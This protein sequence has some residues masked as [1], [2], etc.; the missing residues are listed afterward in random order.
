MGKDQSRANLPPAVGLVIR[1]GEG[2]AIEFK[3]KYTGRI[4]EDIAAFAN[5]KGGTI[6]LG[7]RDDGSIVGERLTNDLKARIVS[8]ARNCNP[9]IAISVAQ[10][11][12]VVTVEVPEGSEKPYGCGSGYFRRLDATSQKMT[13]DELRVMFSQNAPVSFEDGLAKGLIPRD[14]SREKVG[15]FLKEAGI[16]KVSVS[17]SELLH[18]LRVADSAGVKIAGALFFARDPGRFVPQAQTILLAFKGTRKLQIYDRQDVRDDLLTQFNQTITFLKKHLNLRSEIRG[19]NRQDSYEIPLEA[20]REAVVNALMH[21]DY[22]VTGTQVSVEVYEDRVEIINPGGLPAGLPQAAFGSMSVRRNELIADLFFRLHKVE[23]IG[24]GIARMREAIAAAGLRAP[25]FKS[26]GYFR[27]VIYRPKPKKGVMAGA[28]LAE[29]GSQKS[30][31][32]KPSQKRAGGRLKTAV[33]RGSVSQKTSQESSQKIRR[34]TSRKIL[35]LIKTNPDITIAGLASQIG[36]TDRAVKYHLKSLTQKGI[37]RR[38][39][40]DKGGH[41]EMA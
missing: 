18:S 9:G 20:L 19:V 33:S 16:V 41:W 26:N 8:L 40:P 14:I 34:K 29:N 4:D 12:P 31:Q 39:G 37:V 6:L 21:R 5:S 28:S 7:V 13:R 30:D 15:A 36:I 3:E 1:E 22:S 38:V 35:D 25:R 23:R 27:A 32:E 17:S 2:L 10:A 11:G 24:M